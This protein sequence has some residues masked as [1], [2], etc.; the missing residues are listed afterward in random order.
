MYIS[1]DTF[2]DVLGIVLA[3]GKD[4]IAHLSYKRL[5]PFS[6]LLVSKIDGVFKEYGYSPQ[7]LEGIVVNKGP[8]GY[9]GL[10]VGITTA[11]TIAYTLSIPVYTYTSL[12]AM[13]Y[14]HRFFCGEIL[15]G[16]YA[17]Q[18]EV[19]TATFSTGGKVKQQGDIKLVK[20]DSFIQTATAFK[21][22]V[23]VKNIPLE[24]DNIAH[25]SDDLAV[26]GYFTTLEEKTEEDLFRLEPIY[27]RQL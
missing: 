16:V 5:K 21:G 20:K 3:D 18:G 17:G 22:L 4:I 23:V 26:D 11:K 7:D 6:E 24:G 14:R 9:S 19:Y 13:A 25:I 8:G 27:L 15:T 2:S 1:I 10:R 12:K